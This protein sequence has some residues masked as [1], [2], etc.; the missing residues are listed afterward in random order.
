[1]NPYLDSLVPIW[2]KPSC[3]F[4]N[5]DALAQVADQL[6]GK[7]F[8]VP[9][10]LE[11][12][13]PP[14]NDEVFVNFIGV[15]NAINFAFSDFETRETFTTDYGN[16]TWHGAFAMW[17]C[18]KRALDHGADFRNLSWLSGLSFSDASSL[19]RGAFEI[20]LL[21]KRIEI[22][23]ETA[24]VLSAGYR[25]SFWRMIEDSRFSAF[26]AH[27]LVETLVEEVPSFRDESFH[28]P[29]G[30]TL[31]FHKRAQ[32]MGMMYQGRAMAG[33]ELPVLRDYEFLGPI[34]D[35]SVPNALRT[36]GILVYVDALAFCRCSWRND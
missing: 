16:Q 28:E 32:L 4:I 18:L 34:A 35:Y 25:G 36:A 10:W 31:Q 12:V 29:S 21:R 3:V 26:G 17:A 33:H 5:S 7:D 27:G 23:H 2:R 14:A 15:G 20:P 24:D 19:F 30:T 8:P 22:L 13:F 6:H 9:S 11:P 1:M